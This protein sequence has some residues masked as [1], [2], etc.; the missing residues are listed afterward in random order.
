M[1]VDPSTP[2]VPLKGPC[3]EHPI[4]WPDPRIAF[5]VIGLPVPQGSKKVVPTRAGPRA[6]ESNE[7]KIR[8]WR[9]TLSAAAAEAMGGRTLLTGPV[10]LKVEFVFP[11]PKGHFGTG[12]NAGSVKHSAPTY[13]STK[14]DLDKLVRA[15]GDALSGV[16]V[17]DDSQIA[18]VNVWKVYGEPA[19]A[20]ISVM[21]L[22][23]VETEAA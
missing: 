6:I 13:V 4:K 22:D 8:P 5:T 2:R 18:H 15:I 11:R 14:P 20:T 16:V 21:S 7:K 17:R 23:V 9:A 1:R 12:R 10:Q 19:Q 3:D